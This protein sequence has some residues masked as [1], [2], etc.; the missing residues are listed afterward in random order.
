MSFSL[1]CENHVCRRGSS[2]RMNFADTKR[3]Q[4]NANC[5]RYHRR[6]IEDGASL[7][8]QRMA[9]YAQSNL[10][11]S[12]GSLSLQKLKLRTYCGS[13][14]SITLTAFSVSVRAFRQITRRSICWMETRWL[15]TVHSDV[16][17]WRRGVSVKPLIWS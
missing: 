14:T 3:S 8:A 9:S 10:Q 7:R 11:I 6:T 12:V 5:D 1:N 15:V 13:M 17:C 4:I 2:P 16:R